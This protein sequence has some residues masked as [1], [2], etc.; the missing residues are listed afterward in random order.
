VLF[1]ILVA[2]ATLEPLYCAWL[3]PLRIIYDPP[4]VNTTIEWM[5]ALIFVTGGLAFLIVGPFMTKKR[6]YCS[7]ICPLLPANALVGMLSP[8]RVKVNRE[9]CND[10]GACVK[11]CESFAITDETLAK[12]NTTIEC[13]RCGRCMDICPKQA[14]DYRL[15]GTNI[16]V[17][18]VFVTLA[19]VFNMLLLSGY[20]NGLVHYLLTGEISLF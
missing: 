20:I 10:C 6:M 3:C 15:I 19:V 9:K 12:G 4:A 18:P 1:L 14:I 5:M 2:I 17:R 7:F 16:G 13:S 11:L 8:F